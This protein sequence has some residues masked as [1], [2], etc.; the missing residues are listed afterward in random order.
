MCICV[1]L[2]ALVT[3][4][5]TKYNVTEDVGSIDVTVKVDKAVAYDFNISIRS[6]PGTAVGKLNNMYVL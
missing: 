4:E 1:C 3:F 5:R 2:D 6:V